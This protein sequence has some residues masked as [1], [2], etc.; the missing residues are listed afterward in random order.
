MSCRSSWRCASRGVR[1][2][3]RLACAAHGAGSIIL[4]PVDCGGVEISR[5]R[6]WADEPKRRLS[7]ADRGCAAA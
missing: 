6:E 4:F 2:A 7:N 3:P 1:G 5:N